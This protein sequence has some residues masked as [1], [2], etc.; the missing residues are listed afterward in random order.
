M[1]AAVK[2][3][4]Q[5]YIARKGVAKDYRLDPGDVEVWCE[6]E[7]SQ[8]ICVVGSGERVIPLD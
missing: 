6:K 8:L 3:E 1:V 7:N 4:N 2:H 5:W